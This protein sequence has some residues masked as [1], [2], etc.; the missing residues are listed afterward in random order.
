MLGRSAEH[1]GERWLTA[2]RAAIDAAIAWRGRTP[3]ALLAIGHSEGAVFAGRL[4]VADA[5][6]T[7]AALLAATPVSQAHDFF[8]MAFAGRGYI[9]QAPGGRAAHL[10]NDAYRDHAGAERSDQCEGHATGPSVPVLGRQ[11]LRRLIFGA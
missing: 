6:V 5:R 2:I 9:A 8:A 7:H 4:A 10:R 1:T 11:R 3:R